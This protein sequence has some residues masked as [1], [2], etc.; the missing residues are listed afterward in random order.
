VHYMGSST[1]RGGAVKLAAAAMRRL[2]E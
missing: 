1:D 2:A